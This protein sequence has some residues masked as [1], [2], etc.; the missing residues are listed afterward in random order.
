M[1]PDCD[2]AFEESTLHADID[3]MVTSVKNPTSGHIKAKGYGE[4][5]ID[6]NI[7]SPANCK[8]ET[9]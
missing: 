4:V 6:E 5:I 3:S 1:A 2:L 9:L 8:I 7:K